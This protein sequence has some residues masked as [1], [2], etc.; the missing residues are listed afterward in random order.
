MCAAGGTFG[1]RSPVLQPTA[2]RKPSYRWAALSRG[3]SRTTWPKSVAL[4][5]SD[6]ANR[7]RL[8]RGGR[9]AAGRPERQRPVPC[10]RA[11]QRGGRESARGDRGAWCGRGRGRV[12]PIPAALYAA[13]DAG[14]A[15]RRV[16]RGRAVRRGLAPARGGSDRRG[17]RGAVTHAEAGRQLA[18]ALQIIHTIGL[19]GAAA[20]QLAALAHFTVD[21]TR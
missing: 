19:D 17:R 21:R 16:A 14:R 2:R 1:G 3:V 6:R 8:G 18:Q 12:S 5:A 11:A 20:R 10:V 9:H 4:P 7:L 15:T 13:T